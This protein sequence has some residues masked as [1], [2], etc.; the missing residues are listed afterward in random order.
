MRYAL[1]I[2]NTRTISDVTKGKVLATATMI[3]FWG[4]VAYFVSR[5]AL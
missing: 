5:I 3:M 1:K 4:G 2:K